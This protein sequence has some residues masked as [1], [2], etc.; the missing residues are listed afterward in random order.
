MALRQIIITRRIA[1]L[2]NEK[3]ALAANITAVAERRTAWLARE[4]AAVAALDEITEETSAEERAAF[5]AEAAEIETENAAITAD[6]NANTTRSAEIDA[7]LETLRTELSGIEERARQASARQS[8][9]AGNTTNETT[10]RGENTMNNFT[11]E[12]R[13]RI[14]EYC[15]A[16]AVKRWL[17]DTRAVLRGVSNVTL[18]I[19]TVVLPSIRERVTAYSK[20]MQYVTVKPIRGDGK[21]TIIGS[22]PEAVWTTTLGKFNEV[23]FNIAQITVDG[24]KVAAFVPVPNAYIQ[25]SDED[26]AALV[27]DMLGQAIGK[28]V[29]KAI[30]Y[31]TGTNMPVGIVPRLV[32]ATSPSWWDTNAPT[33]TNLSTSHVGKQS[34]TSVTGNALLKEMLKVLGTVKPLYTMGN[35]QKVWIMNPTTWTD[36]KIETLTNNQAGAIVAG[37]NNTMPIIGGTIVELDF[38]PANVVVGGYLGHYLL[39]ERAGVEFRKSEH[40]KF[41]DDETVFAGVARY[42]GKPV[43]GEAFAAFSLTTTAVSGTAVT[44]A[45]DSANATQTTPTNPSQSGDNG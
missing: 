28:A 26:L 2:E 20:L 21:Q 43:A 29:D 14:T 3:Q 11:P 22:A 32:A 7:E 17:N 45:T 37:L 27:I 38:M 25:D 24:E 33:F 40:I 9:N 42:D 8:E 5:E 10:T 19:P 34:A 18:T 39:G 1:E 4:A 13:A 35:D 30:L 15:R 44:F 31:G 6:E 16:D 36:I 12:Y 41:I 23:S